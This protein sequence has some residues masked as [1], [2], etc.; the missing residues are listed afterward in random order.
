MGVELNPISVVSSTLEG[1]F[2]SEWVGITGIIGGGEN[3][4]L[5]SLTN[6]WGDCSDVT[7]G[8]FNPSSKGSSGMSGKGSTG[9]KG[10]LSLGIF[11]L[12]TSLSNSNKSCEHFTSVNPSFWVPYKKDL[13]RAPYYIPWVQFPL[14]KD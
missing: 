12:F 13:G 10:S 1:N 7:G 5:S 14:R 6:A 2:T 4:H 9:R 11:I 8:V 3:S